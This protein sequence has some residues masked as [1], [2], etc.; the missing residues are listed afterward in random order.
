MQTR[1]LALSAL[2]A[3]IAFMSGTAGA[4]TPELTGYFRSGAG[5]NT[6]GGNIV[7]YRL[8]GSIVWFRLGN[9]CDTYVALTLGAELGKVDGTT[10]KAKFTT[11]HGTQGLANWEQS[12]PALRE[13]YV[14]ATD[15]G[16]GLKMPALNGASLWAGKRFY[17]NPDIHMLDYTYWEPGMG[18]GFGLDNVSVGP[19]KLSYAMLRIGDFTGYGIN[20]SLGGYNP[21]LIGGGS[22]TATVHDLRWQDIPVNPGGTVTAGLN[23]VRA[24][25]RGGTSSYTT[26]STVMADLDNNPATPDVAVVVRNTTTI[27]NKPGKNGLGLTLTHDQANPFGM[28]GKNTV[29]VQYAHNAVSLKGFGFA[30]STDQRREWM[31]FDSWYVAPKGTA[32][33]ATSTVGYRHSK[34]NNDTV[35]E[36]WIGTR[37]VYN[38]NNIWSVMAEVGHQ[39]LS[40]ND[41]PTSTLSKITLGTQFSM[42]P[43]VWAR[44]AIRFYTTYAKWND[45][46]AVAGAVA[47]SGRDCNNAADGFTNKRSGLSYGVQV[48]A[49]F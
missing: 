8:P 14:E 1:F 18:P 42:G 26:D 4:V 27:S 16:A 28:G 21:D 29:G 35:K 34:I 17:K 7:C 40:K 45:A 43:G 33:S 31:L 38:L 47:C 41:Q 11:A 23:L 10:F 6:E 2:T 39:R 36:L 15:L 44:P 49:W 9:E 24:N 37:P 32:F 22:R 12:T 5:S 13:A 25:N 3:G 19:G 20:T 30:G 48:E 46:A